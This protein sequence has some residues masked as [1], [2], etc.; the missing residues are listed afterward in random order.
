MV[1]LAT[2]LRGGASVCCVL[3]VAVP[4]R[5]QWGGRPPRRSASFERLRSV[6]CHLVGNVAETRAVVLSHL[7]GASRAI[8]R[9]VAALGSCQGSEHSPLVL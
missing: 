1:G 7:L 8:S 9:R 3:V 4:R 6:V 2:P 5:C